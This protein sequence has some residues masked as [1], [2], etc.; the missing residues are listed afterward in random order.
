[1]PGT[2]HVLRWSQ[3]QGRVVSVGEVQVYVGST[4]VDHRCAVAHEG[5]LG[6]APRFGST[7]RLRPVWPTRTQPIRCPQA[8]Q[9]PKFLS[10]VMTAVSLIDSKL[11]RCT[12]P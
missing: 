1:M 11:H 10:S 3:K 6:V 12:P 4:K 2:G 7:G 5:V 9:V 8:V